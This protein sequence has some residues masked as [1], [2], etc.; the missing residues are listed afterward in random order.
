MN[1][2]DAIVVFITTA[3][4]LNAERLARILVERR[5]AACVQIVPEIISVYRWQ[6]AV[7]ADAEVLLLVKT[8]REKFAMLETA[9][10]ANHSYDVPEILAVPAAEVSA[11]YLNWLLENTA[12]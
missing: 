11:P 5:L 1:S 6:N 9:V 4:R 2:T 7:Q 8:V 12:D 10:R 3:N